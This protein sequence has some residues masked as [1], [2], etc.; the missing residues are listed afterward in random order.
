MGRW[1]TLH[2]KHGN[3][4]VFLDNVDDSHSDKSKSGG[5]SSIKDT[6]KYLVSLTES[7][8]TTESISKIRTF[9]SDYLNNTF[10][11]SAYEEDINKIKRWANENNIKITSDIDSSLKGKGTKSYYE[12][13]QEQ[14]SEKEY[15]RK[16]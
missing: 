4:K 15:Y 16:K 7:K 3:Y 12:Y 1:V 14:N 8:P 2:G 9:L 5:G 10:K 6:I 11:Y 13:I